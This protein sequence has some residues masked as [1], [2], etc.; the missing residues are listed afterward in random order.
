LNFFLI[1][2]KLLKDKLESMI[3]I[4]VYPELF[5]NK[6]PILRSRACNLKIH[7]RLVN[8]KI[9]KFEIFRGQSK[10]DTQWIIKNFE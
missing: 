8:W 1:K 4:Y 7:T 6:F 2:N 5:N 3:M 10:V 9:F